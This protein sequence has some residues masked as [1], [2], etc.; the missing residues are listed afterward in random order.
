MGQLT[1]RGQDAPAMPHIVLDLPLFKDGRLVGVARRARWLAWPAA[2]IRGTRILV[3]DD[4]KETA[5]LMAAA[6]RAK[7][8]QA[9]CTFDGVSGLAAARALLPDLVVLNLTMPGLTGFDVLRELRADGATS[10]IKVIITSAGAKME[11]LA[12]AAREL[13]A[14]DFLPLPGTPELML[15]MVEKALAPGPLPG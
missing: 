12:A 1:R 9:A 4:D 8:Y 15:A 6:L 3:V 10:H 14:Q 7:G 13:G 2:L 11:V 5:R